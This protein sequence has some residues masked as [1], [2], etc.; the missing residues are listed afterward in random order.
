[1]LRN[2]AIM[3]LGAIAVFD[4][5]ILQKIQSLLSNRIFWVLLIPFLVYSL[6]LIYTD[7]LDIG[8]KEIEKKAS[9]LLFPIIFGL[10]EIKQ[11][12]FYT[13]LKSLVFLISF[14]P[15]IGFCVQWQIYLETQDSGW[16]YNDNLVSVLNKQAVYYALFVNTAI[17]ILIHLFEKH[18]LISL[19]SRILAGSSL[20]LLLSTQYLLAS[21]TSMIVTILILASYIGWLLL[22]KLNKKQGL[23]LGLGAIA[24]FIALLS[25]FPK[26]INR[27]KSLTN[28][29]YQYNNP[30]PINHF[31]VEAKNENWNGLNTR[32]AIWSCAWEEFKQSPW[33]GHGVGDVQKVLVDNYK[34]KNF[35][36]GLKMNYNSHNQYLDVIL[37]FGLIGLLL[38]ILFAS[39]LTSIA[40]KSGS[41]LPLGFLITFA[42]ACITENILSRDQGIVFVSIL[43]AFLYSNVSCNETK[44]AT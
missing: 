25:F 17:L 4:K 23:V 41:L 44:S 19:V 24:L 3:L 21:R 34:Q 35:I 38:F 10:T 5:N 18:Q 12:D 20:V 30:N 43:F 2:Y 22:K 6:G 27:Y 29:E 8:L 9:L 11:R 32:L 15:I 36:L 42:I 14:L 39:V 33:L 7:D 16:L 40:L 26:V 1:M 28:I 37:T 31:N 13:V